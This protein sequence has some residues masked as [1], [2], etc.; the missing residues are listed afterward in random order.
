MEL[1]VEESDLFLELLDG[2]VE[3]LSLDD[4]MSEDGSDDWEEVGDECGV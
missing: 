3:D 4:A 1:S 2:I